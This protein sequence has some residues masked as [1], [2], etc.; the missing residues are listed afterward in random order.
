MFTKQHAGQ[1]EE[2]MKFYTQVFPQS[3]MNIMMRYSADQAPEQEGTVAYAEFSILGQ[4]F[5][6]MD[7][8]DQH[9][10]TFSEAV[11][12]QVS[13]ENQDEVD[14]YWAKL[15]ADPQAEACGWL[16][17]KYG[18]SWQIV[19]KALDDMMKNGTPDQIERLM[20]AFMPMKK[21]N[22]AELERAYNQK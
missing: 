22:I 13:C 14:N 2:A 18:V 7:S 20:T 15:S 1:A 19:P 21:I 17:D 16:K 3:N 6:A 4:R 9:D 5:G 10:F 11:S 8:A 12:L